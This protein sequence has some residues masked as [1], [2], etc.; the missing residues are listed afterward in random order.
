VGSACMF[1][2]MQSKYWVFTLNN[3]D[4]S[5]DF[6]VEFRDRTSYYVIGKEVGESGTKHLQ[7]YAEFTTP[8]RLSTVRRILASAHWEKR[9][10]S[11]E[12][13][14]AYCKKDGD[15]TEAGQIS[16]P[17]PGRRTDLE[18]AAN[19]I[20]DGG[21]LLDVANS[22]STTFVKFHK[23]LLAL[24]TTIESGRD[25]VVPT[26]T[27]FWGPTGTGKSY[28]VRELSPN[29]FFTSNCKWYDGYDGQRDIC[30]D[31]YAGGITLNNFL[32]LLDRYPVTVE[33]KGGT[34]NFNPVNIFITS[35]FDPFLW[36]PEQQDRYPEL[37]RRFTAVH[38][39]RRTDNVSV[40]EV[41]GNTVPPPQSQCPS[42][43]FL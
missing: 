21:S 27:V 31:D 38:E 15:Y 42:F 14:A 39:F 12:Q 37:E 20:R 23:G 3:Y 10:G 34:I 35:H 1:L 16:D 30:F 22:H 11:A 26:V 6:G 24:K 9:R 32:R 41:G 29:C 25:K 17:T 40:S 13:A 8:K 19:I 43:I 18:S 33:C 5:R 4:E 7:G 36:Y 28:R 2:E